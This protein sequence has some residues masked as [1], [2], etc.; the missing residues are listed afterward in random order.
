MKAFFLANDYQA[1]SVH[2]GPSS[3]SRPE[4][5][6]DLEN[7]TLSIL[8]SVDLFNEG[9]DIPEIDCV[10]MLRP[11]ESSII[12][13]QQLGRGLRKSTDKTHL[14]VL[15]LVGNHQSFLTKIR[16]L[17]NLGAGK[18]IGAKEAIEILEDGAIE[19]PVGCSVLVETEALDLMKVLAGK[20]T[21]GKA[22]S[23]ALL[24]WLTSH[25]QKRP[26]ALGFSLYLGRALSTPKKLGGWFDF[27][28]NESLLTLS[29]AETLAQ[30]KDW[31]LYME[32]GAYSKSYKLVTLLAFCQLGGFEKPVDLSELMEACRKRIYGDP[33]L[34][35]DLEDATS[36]F[37]DVLNP[38]N[39]EWV[40]C[41][42]TNPL[43]ALTKPQGDNPTWMEVQDG[44]LAFTGSSSASHPSELALMTL[45]ICEYRLHRYLI[46][47]KPGNLFPRLQVKD[48]SGVALNSGFRVES[49]LGKPIAVFV[50]S[51]GADRNR[52][53]PLGVSLILQ[54]LASIGARITDAYVDSS[55]VQNLPLSERRLI[56]LSSIGYLDLTELDTATLQKSMLN[57]MAAVGRA[58]DAKG[59]GNSRKS[60]KIVI[61]GVSP[62]TARSVS[63]FL[64]SGD[65]SGL[66][67]AR[68][69]KDAG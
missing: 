31:F 34:V 2:S 47:K 33:R 43:A 18:V 7:G 59:K 69:T 20:M 61:D 68:E 67:F 53:Y 23:E 56:E 17:A 11:T 5:L 25:E 37:A 19:L 24:G 48:D 40:T 13:F 35:V 66:D 15:D 16:L 8:F 63:D 14:D 42:T 41:W 12:F 54:R 55:K 3:D 30:A 4:A 62:W 51:A 1:A 36:F 39:D 52:D 65:R 44:M 10:L 57:K 28:A 32:R 46:G 45:E 49:I 64:V 22:L 60:M 26:S 6:A 50:E 38:T 29:E 9:V 27:L 58:K 21:K